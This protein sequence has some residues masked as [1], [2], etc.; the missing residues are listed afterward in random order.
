MIDIASMDTE[1]TG[2]DTYHGCRPYLV[3]A[4]T[5]RNNYAWKGEVDPSSREVH[6]RRSE[7]LDLLSFIN[8]CREL[9]F[10][11]HNF[12]VRMI[13]TLGIPLIPNAIRNLHNH[14]DSGHI[15][16]PDKFPITHD[17]MLSSHCV[18]SGNKK[19][20]HPHGLKELMV[21]YFGYDNSDEDFLQS[22]TVS[23]RNDL[24][25][26]VQI[27]KVGHPHFPAN[28]D[29]SW[30]QDMWLAYG[31]CV[32]YGVR[33]V[34]RT[35]LLHK[36]LIKYIYEI[37]LYPQYAFRLKLLKV[38]YDMQT[39]GIN[40]YANKAKRIV[41]ELDTQIPQLVEKMR[42]ESGIP[43]EFDPASR[44][45]LDFFLYSALKLP[46]INVTATGQRSTDDA[47]LKIFEED[48]EHLTAIRYFR[49]WRKATKKRTDINTY[50]KWAEPNE[51]PALHVKDGPSSRSAVKPLTLGEAPPSNL[52]LP[53]DKHGAV[54][55]NDLYQPWKIHSN[56]HISGTKW[57]RGSTSD[58]NQQNFDKTLGFLFGP[59]P[60]YV[61]LYC[62]V[63]NIELR[64]WAYEVGAAD[65]IAAFEAGQSVHMIIAKAL[66]PEILE[67]L[68][69]KAFKETKYYTNCK[70]GTFSRI[71]GAGIRKCNDTY[72]VANAC[73]VIDELCPEIG[74]YFKS[75]TKMMDDNAEIF[76][77]PC[78]FTRQGYKLDV[79]VSSPHSVPSARIQGTAALIV[80]EMQIEVQRHPLYKNP[81]GLPLPSPPP[82]MTVAQQEIWNTTLGLPDNLRC[83]QIQQVH[84]SLNIKMP[85]HD[86]QKETCQQL[87][88]FMETIACRTIPTCPLDYDIIECHENEEPFFL[89]YLFVPQEHNG[90]EIQMF[91][92][93][94][95]YL[96][97]ATY[98][99]DHVIKEYGASRQEAFTKVINTIDDVPF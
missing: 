35:L 79:P 21:K 89:D 37:N 60:G 98:S 39:A 82:N 20:G 8:E 85:K 69:A 50:V 65:L 57:T 77:Y 63:V 52:Q 83:V 88:D 18:C 59:E 92:H 46:A 34:E 84:D 48:Y 97:V 4:C 3:T 93:N 47:T 74:A 42:V 23:A 30:A 24:K 31:A 44:E 81:L 36:A 58:P 32:Y 86:N 6:W 70:G 43:W 9:V 64:I 80:Q 99:Q 38:F 76:H 5:G 40:Y 7:I 15:H 19:V 62:D 2:L 75:L 13:A 95:Q 16:I 94:H 33:D 28:T 12:D 67:R 11:N 96:C 56:I 26:T 1:A 73:A 45:H 91:I 87:I 14:F 10:H 72:G 29:A 71:Y 55:Y 27:A 68:G 78:V 90:F 25:S 53:P 61:W 22:E 41:A 66:Y 51:T 49:N 17:T 54:L